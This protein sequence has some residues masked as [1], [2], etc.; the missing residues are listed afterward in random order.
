M[1]SILRISLLPASG[2]DL[3]IQSSGSNSAELRLNGGNVTMTSSGNVNIGVRHVLPVYL[4]LQTLQIG[5]QEVLFVGDSPFDLQ[6]GRAAGVRTG[7]AT[8]GP[9]PR[10]TLEAETPDFLFGSFQEVLRACLTLA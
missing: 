1:N 2:Q 6:S 8:W 4:A 5:S 7:A 3:I 10:A 9:H